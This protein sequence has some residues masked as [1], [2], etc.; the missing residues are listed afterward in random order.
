MKDEIEE[1][2]YKAAIKRDKKKKEQEDIKPIATL[3]SVK[4]FKNDR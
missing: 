4:I 1:I 2:C 3:V